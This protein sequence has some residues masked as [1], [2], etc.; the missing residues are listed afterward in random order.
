VPPITVTGLALAPIKAM[1]LRP[2]DEI[3]L[4]GDGARGDRRCYVIDAGGRM[5]NGKQH[6]QLQAIIAAIDPA[7]TQLSLTFPDGRTVAGPIEPGAPV[8]ARFYRRT[9]ETHELAGPFSPAVSDFIGHPLRLVLARHGADRGARGAVS[10]MSLASVQRLAEQAGVDSIDPRRFRM[11][12]EIDGVSAH[13]E[14]GWVGRRIRVGEA[15]LRP[16][17][18]VG[19]CLITSRDPDTAETTLPT[20][21][22][23]RDYRSGVTATEPLPLGVYGEVLAGGRIRIGDSVQIDDEEAR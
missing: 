8:T 21:D 4:T 17:G 20:L 22:L 18:H 6:A 12:I 3:E 2:V 7:E 15:L 13:A 1:R 9:D 16:Q 19:R 10:I 11:L 23:L 14:D 5:V